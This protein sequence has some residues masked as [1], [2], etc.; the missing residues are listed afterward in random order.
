MNTIIGAIGAIALIVWGIILHRDIQQMRRKQKD[1]NNGVCGRCGIY[2]QRLNGPDE[3]Y[4]CTGCKKQI[5][6]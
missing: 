1:W 5:E 3:R 2:W 4:I 6:M